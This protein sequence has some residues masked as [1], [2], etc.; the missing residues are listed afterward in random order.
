[1]H[2]KQYIITSALLLLEQTSLNN[3]AIIGTQLTTLTTGA[4]SSY[5]LGHSVT[6]TPL[7]PTIYL[8][9]SPGH[10]PDHS[11]AH[12]PSITV[13]IYNHHQQQQQVAAYHL[14]QQQAGTFRT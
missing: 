13:T 14:Q 1:M 9:P 4:K 8:P 5:R 11:S 2:I 10:H 3:L 7:T 6:V 12:T